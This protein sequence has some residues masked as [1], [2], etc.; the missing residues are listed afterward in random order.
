MA[1]SQPQR[2]QRL[3]AALDELV[4]LGL[5]RLGEDD[6]PGTI[7]ALERAGGLVGEIAS[8]AQSLKNSA[9]LPDE[10]AAKASHVRSKLERLEAGLATRRGA[11]KEE[12]RNASNALATIRASRPAYGA[13]KFGRSSASAPLHNLDVKS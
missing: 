5:A 8:L 12:L 7:L 6:T 10:L 1:E 3:L 2:L 13:Y 9:T 4:S 11:V